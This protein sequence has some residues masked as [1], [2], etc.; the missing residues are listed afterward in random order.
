[1]SSEG[2]GS[3][4]ACATLARRTTPASTARCFV[5]G[6][7]VIRARLMACATKANWAM[8]LAVVLPIGA[9]GSGAALIARIA[10]QDILVLAAVCLAPG[11]QLELERCALGM[12]FALTARVDQA[13]VGVLEDG[14]RR[15]TA[16]T[17]TTATSDLTAKTCA[18]ERPLR[19]YRAAVTGSAFLDIGA[20][21]LVSVQRTL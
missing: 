19:A 7:R 9:L 3:P 6:A 16:P 12:E 21:A 11:P 1:M 17:V 20:M 14:G 13:D 8:G 10:F 4:V 18:Q 15:R 5:Q 2:S